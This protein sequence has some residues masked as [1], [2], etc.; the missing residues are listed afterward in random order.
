MSN[1][2]A[3]RTRKRSTPC[4]YFIFTRHT[5]LDGRIKY[6]STHCNLFFYLKCRCK[7]CPTFFNL[8]IKWCAL[9][10]FLFVMF[11]S[12]NSHHR[13]HLPNITHPQSITRNSQPHFITYHHGFP[14][15]KNLY[16]W[17]Q[18]TSKRWTIGTPPPS[19]YHDPYKLTTLGQ[20]NFQH[21]SNP[22]YNNATTVSLYVGQP[23][24]KH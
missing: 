7:A 10:F 18:Q 3:R 8:N 19:T 17:P 14:I 11:L 16:Q 24:V 9:S 20:P 12:L 4:L 23:A 22:Y 13:I 1:K 6:Y 21:H 15:C 5:P 2:R